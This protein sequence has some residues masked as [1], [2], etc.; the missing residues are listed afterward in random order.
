MKVIH[1]IPSLDRSS[2]GTTAYMQLLTKELGRLVELY[3]VSH[4]S[5]NPVVMDNCEVYFIPEFRNFMEMKRQ[6]RILLTQLQPDVVHMNCCWMPACAFTQKWA[7]A[8]GYKVVLTP[9]GMLEPWI[10][11]RH[12]WSKKVPALLLYQKAAVVKADVLHA[13]AKSEKEN[14]LKLGYNDRIKIIANGINVE[15]IEMKPS[16]KRNKE[17]LFLSR[18]HVKK[19]INFLL[20]AVAQL[21][22][23]MEG[24][25]IR[26]AGE[27]DATYIEELKQLAAR[28]GISQLII[29]EGGVYGNRKW[30]LFRQADLFIL[31]TYSEN[32]GI[33]VAEALASGTPVITTM[34]T[35]WSELESQHCGWWTEVGTE[36]TVQAL[37]NFLSLT[38]DELEV[39][40]HNGR[41]LVEE[42]YSA[43]KVAKEFV[44]MYK[45]IL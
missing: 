39:M 30:E 7:Q 22:E 38:E 19:G 35:P 20:E 5:E 18:I 37:C 32:F 2:G 14:L 16:W 24:Y 6:W 9:H 44:D 4:A 33:V 11:A 42:K 8:L 3:V 40:G 45:S 10:M 13:T 27:G 43:H 36:A 29:F 17:I 1:Y 26:I 34:G 41:K 28:L 25:V 23:Q 12:Y 21:K 31:P 15:D